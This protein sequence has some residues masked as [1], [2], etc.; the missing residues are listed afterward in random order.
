M[1]QPY[2]TEKGKQDTVANEAGVPPVKEKKIMGM[3]KKS[4]WIVLVVLVLCFVLGVGLGAGLGLGLNKDD[5]AYVPFLS[6]RAE[7]KLTPMTQ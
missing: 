7:C 4:F 3:R 5:K 6:Q 1:A 2:G